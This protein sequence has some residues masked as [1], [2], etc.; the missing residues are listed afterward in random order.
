MYNKMTVQYLL[1]RKCEFLK[2]K[3]R[4]FIAIYTMQ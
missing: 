3:E 4:T 2:E 1:L